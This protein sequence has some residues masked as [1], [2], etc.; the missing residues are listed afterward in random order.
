MGKISLHRCIAHARF[1]LAAALVVALPLLLAT[2]SAQARLATIQWTDP[3]PAPSPVTNFRLH[4]GTTSGS[5]GAIVDLGLPTPNASGVFTA[6]A[7]VPDDVDV[8]I[9]MTAFEVSGLESAWSN[10]Q[11]LAAPPPAGDQLPDGQIDSPTGSPVIAAG[12]SIAFA[13]SGFDPDGGPVTYSWDFDPIGSDVP[14]STQQNP[15][16]VTFP[17]A[18]TFVV[19]LTVTDDEGNSDPSPATI[20]V[21]V[22]PIASQPPGGGNAGVTGL[23]LAGRVTTDS[24]VAAAPDGDTRLFV[25]ARSGLIRVVEGGYPRATAFLDLSDD[26]SAADGYGGVLGLV[27]D[28]DYATNGH[29]FVTRVDAGG[30]LVLSRFSLGAHPYV[31]DRASEVQLLRLP[32]PHAGNPGGGLAFGPGGFLFV[33]VGDGGGAGDPDDRAQDPTAL[34]GKLL[35]LDVGVPAAADSIAAG[36]YSIPADN[37][38]LGGSTRDEIWALGLRDP[39]RISVDRQTGALWI[40]DP[41]AGVREEINFESGTDAGGHNYGWDVTSGT[42]CNPTDPSPAP[43]C[44]DPGITDPIF[45][46]TA[47]AS[48]CGIIGGHVYRGAHLEFQGQYFFAAGCSGN[49]W[50]YDRVNDQLYNRTLE[51]LEGGTANPA[52]IALA[53]GGTGELYVLAVDGRVHQIRSDVP[54]CRD[55]VDNDADGLIDY[56]QDPGC[57]DPDAE[58]EVPLCDDGFDNDLD[59]QID[60]NDP[61]CGASHQ[62]VEAEAAAL[63]EIAG[64]EIFC[65]LGAELVFIIPAFMWLRRAGRRAVR[66]VGA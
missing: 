39:A 43:S 29:L 36:A 60:T 38:F 63:H 65:G 3:N 55:G 15:G 33:G 7:N 24:S 5:Y 47:S 52:A 51:F 66:L 13:G 27:F 34:H 45:E 16:A 17:N 11:V 32:L 21:D 40:S 44:S 28:P 46:Y 8:Y 18:G 12:Q 41:G 9:V 42:L 50:S 54:S 49:V 19:T 35:R 57:A 61:E 20:V 6:S 37:P 31:A 59:G 4:V 14:G 64:E 53:E 25:A 58:T 23:R 2:G 22:Q 48:S 30:D 56:P 1:R 62:N 10:E 26:V